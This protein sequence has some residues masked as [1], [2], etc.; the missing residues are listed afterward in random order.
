MYETYLNVN[1]KF[2][3]SVN[4]QYDLLDDEKIAQY[5]PTTDLCDV[6]KSYVVSVLE[7]GKKSTFL[8]GPYGKGK[9]YLMLMITYIFSKKTNKSLFKKVV[10]KIRNIDEELANYIL[11]VDRRNIVLL[12]V[13]INNGSFDDLNQN[14]MLA[15]SNALNDA[16]LTNIVPNTSYK[17]CLTLLDKWMNSNDS[18]FNVLN[19]CNKFLKIDINELKRG[20]E[21]YDIKYYKKFEELF[22][23]ISRGYSFNPLISND[24]AEIYS[25][26]SRQIKEYGYTGIFT[27][28]DEFG[29]FLSNQSGDFAKRLY[30]IQ[31]FA[32]K[33]EASEMD[34]QM[35]FCCIT[36]K[37]VTLYSKEKTYFDEFEKIAG[38]FKQYR[39]DRSLDEN[40]Q[41]ICSAIEKKEGYKELVEEEEKN[42]HD[43]LTNLKEKYLFSS[44]RQLSY[45]FKNGFPFNPIS[46]YALIQVSEKVAQNERTLFT[47]LSDIDVNS[48]NFFVYN[49]ESGLLNVPTIYDYFETLIRD[50]AEYK[51]LY[52]KVESLIKLTIKKEERDIIKS[53]AVIKLINDSVKFNSTIENIAFCLAKNRQEIDSIIKRLLDKNLLKRNVNDNTI[54][55]SVI[56]DEDLNNLITQTVNNKFSNVSVSELLSKFDQNKYYVS[57]KYNFENK[58]TRYYKSL[59]FESSK[60]LELNKLDILFD[61]EFSDGIIINLIND[62]K[63]S[64]TVIKKFLK[65][66]N[67]PNLII[68]YK[69]EKISKYIIE[70][71]REIFAS[72]YLLDNERNISE[73]AQSALKVMINDYS[74]EVKKY[75]SNFYNTSISLNII[76]I[77]ERNL[78]NCI[79]NSLSNYY[80][81]TVILNNEQI[82]KNDISSVSL[83]ARNNVIQSIL[84]HENTDFGTTSAEAT[85]KTSFEE[86]VNKNIQ[87]I[88]IIEDWFIKSNGEKIS[89]KDLINILEKA[90]YGMR[91]GAM[92]LFIAEAISNLSVS[93]EQMINT[94][95][96]YNGTQEIDLNSLNIG[97]IVLDPE[98][99]YFC[100]AKINYEKINMLKQ[101]MNIFK[102]AET[103]SFNENMQKLVKAMKFNASNLAP[104]IVKTSKKENLYN[105]S[106]DA[107]KYKDLFLK[108]DLNNYDVLFYDLPKLFECEYN[109]VADKVIAILNEYDEKIVEYY[110]SI[111]DKILNIFED[112]VSDS[113]KSSFDMWKIKYDYIDD[114]IFENN[115]K[116]LFNAFLQIKYND[117]DSIKV[118]SFGVL[119]CTLEDWNF[120]KYDLF[121][122]TLN[123]FV[124]T[125]KN[126]KKE[127]NISKNDYVEKEEYVFSSLG[128]TLYSN[129]MDSIDEYGESL[130]NEEKA[131]ILKKVLNELLN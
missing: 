9:S 80:N 27:I 77:N 94:V 101:L 37:D 90:P 122:N 45:I 129:I 89:A 76:D 70:K 1:K 121:F 17:E 11:E 51:S 41:I 23:C 116:N 102:C 29:T 110:N 38:R 5:I 84:N 13:I 33:C 28:F 46:I 119:G 75:I 86:S 48:F 35:H 36:H 62:N 18:G 87:L 8:A 97:K 103:N 65:D 96:L 82:N 127:D 66:K 91:K 73:N 55:F 24:I 21:S 20:L 3:S 54:D 109:L 58:M 2:K 68:R 14:F 52:Y 124:D 114:I 79:F 125:V 100:F 64:Q 57:N 53:I 12:P 16:R 44:E 60:L 34:S 118:L 26:V 104:T 113:I 111:K 72:Q 67:I 99:Y 130:S 105:I 93:S 59:Y 61:G 115:E 32:E 40:Y 120:K 71:I 126:Y 95:I 131:K 7:N 88:K 117:I 63:V 78:S 47:F 85:I 108:H 6:I 19:E 15:L 49:N 98:K 43:F 83:K 74:N 10:S 69:N 92:P 112:S 50:N 30:K 4:L 128:K 123:K 39:F 31:S 56:A 25:D 106:I 42:Y 22:S 107:I 81:K